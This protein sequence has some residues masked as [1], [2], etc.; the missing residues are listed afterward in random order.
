[1]SKFV[2][3]ELAAFTNVIYLRTWN[4]PFCI[5]VSSSLFKYGLFTQNFILHEGVVV[6]T[7]WKVD[8]CSYQHAID[9]S[10]AYVSRKVLHFLMPVMKFSTTW[11]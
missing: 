5:P 7:T 11:R 9:F 4:S 1:M 6:T 8:N 2:K 3:A 10:K